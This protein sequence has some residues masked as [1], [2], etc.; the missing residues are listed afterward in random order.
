M[1]VQVRGVAFVMLEQGECQEASS[2]RLPVRLTT[3]VQLPPRDQEGDWSATAED[4]EP[5]GGRGDK[6]KQA[7]SRTK[8]KQKRNNM[9]QRICA[10]SSHMGLGLQEQELWQ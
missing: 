10:A 7:L 5:C 6:S 3:A 2:W 1:G 8:S 9:S 4:V